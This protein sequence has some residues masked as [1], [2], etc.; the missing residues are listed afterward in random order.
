LAIGCLLAIAVVSEY[1]GLVRLI[2][3]AS[4]STIRPLPARRRTTKAASPAA[5]QLRNCRDTFPGAN[6]SR[7]PR[8]TLRLRNRRDAKCSIGWIGWIGCIGNFGGVLPL[9][10]Q[11]RKGLEQAEPGRSGQAG[12]GGAAPAREHFD[13]PADSG[14]AW[15]VGK[16]SSTSFTCAAKLRSPENNEKLWL[17][18]FAEIL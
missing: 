12:D 1:P 8:R 16:A 5:G 18:P 17:D 9:K 13:H 10:S 6:F 14:A 15:E 4:P 7:P 3:P 11:E 2:T